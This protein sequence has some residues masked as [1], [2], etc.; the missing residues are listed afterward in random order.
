MTQE[1]T[2]RAEVPYL[3]F[4]LPT[5]CDITVVVH[6]FEKCCIIILDD[7]LEVAKWAFVQGWTRYTKYTKDA[8]TARSLGKDMAATHSRYLR[9]QGLSPQ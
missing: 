1:V 2:P 7:A 5:A 9:R 8:S 6:A 3:Q 4:T